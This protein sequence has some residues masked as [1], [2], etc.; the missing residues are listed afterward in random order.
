MSG[1]FAAGL[2]LL[3]LAAGADFIGGRFMR[4]GPLYLLGAAGSACLATLGG[5]AL[6]AGRSSSMSRAGS[7]TRCRASRRRRWRLTGCRGCSWR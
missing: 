3:A 6:A 7:G 5:F 1:L 2:I 4:S